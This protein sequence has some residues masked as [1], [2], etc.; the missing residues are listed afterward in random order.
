MDVPFAVRRETVHD[1]RSGGHRRRLEFARDRLTR[2]PRLERRERL[3]E[4][5]I[6]LV[7]EVEVLA[8]GQGAPRD[9]ALDVLAVRAVR[10]AR[11]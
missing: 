1:E 10:P 5:T 4:R 2:Q 7:V 11:R 9:E 6:G 3:A 8:A